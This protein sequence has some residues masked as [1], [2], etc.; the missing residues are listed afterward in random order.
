MARLVERRGAHEGRPNRLIIFCF[1]KPV[2]NQYTTENAAQFLAARKPRVLVFLDRVRVSWDAG[3]D[4][5]H[6]AD[7]F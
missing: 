5:R 2:I 7:K 6:I 3:S 1:F 4:Q